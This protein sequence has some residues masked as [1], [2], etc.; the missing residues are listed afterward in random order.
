M[1]I[2]VDTF[3][4]MTPFKSTGGQDYVSKPRLIILCFI[5]KGGKGK[6]IYKAREGT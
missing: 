4:D 1:G 6:G 5:Q 2:V 3:L